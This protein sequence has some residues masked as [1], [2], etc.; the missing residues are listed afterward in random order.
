MVRRN[1]GRVIAGVCG[2]L[3]DHLGVDVF[4]VRVVFVVLTALGGAGVL[5]YA[6][7]WFFT[8]QGHDTAPP[9]PRE[10]RQAWGLVL[11]GVVA[12]VVSGMLAANAP[13]QQTVA[14]IF[15]IGGMALVWREFDV[16]GAGT[17][18]SASTWFRLVAGALLV[19]GGLVVMVFGSDAAIGGLSFTIVAVLATLAGVILLTIPMWARLLRALDAERAARI[20]TDEREQIASHL[21]DSVLQTLA[22]IQKQS[23]DPETV[24]RLARRQEREL[25]AWLFGDPAQ[26]RESF[27]A[28]ITALAAEVEEAYG[29]EIEAVTVG[30]TTSD[31]MRDERFAT[32]A[33]ALV[34]ATREALVNAAKHS[35]ADTVDVYCEVADDRVDV[36]VRDRGKGFDPDAVD[37]DRQGLAL[38]VLGRMERV[39]CTVDIR[40]TPGRGTNVT[41]TLPRTAVADDAKTDDATTDDAVPAETEL[42]E[43]EAS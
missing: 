27:A 18:R 15:V 6:A 4:K 22:L 37:E 16:T 28:A 21:H 40:S 13:A 41:L 42:K 23:G 14:A 24:A 19:V 26:R 20:R 25:R 17:G 11:I 43:K 30:D 32:A 9:K 5:A 2:G 1:G 34:G 38:S 29:T 12:L 7:L 10:K 33:T 3:S 36:F 8:P 31:E 35:G 39:G